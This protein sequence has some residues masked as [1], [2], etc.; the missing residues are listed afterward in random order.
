MGLGLALHGSAAL[1]GQPD[2]HCIPHPR[3]RSSRLRRHRGRDCGRAAGRTVK[4]GSGVRVE[5]M[6]ALVSFVA[7]KIYRNAL[8]TKA[9][10][11]SAARIGYGLRFFCQVNEM[12]VLL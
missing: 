9:T 5:Y 10:I 11:Y 2:R 6:A 7:Q 4:Q 12:V 8:K 3:K 1:R